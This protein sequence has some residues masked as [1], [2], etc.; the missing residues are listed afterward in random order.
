[1]PIATTEQYLEMI[2]NAKARKFAYP[3]I[4]IVNIEGLTGA[5]EAFAELE[6]DGMVQVSTGGGAHATG[7]T[8]SAWPPATC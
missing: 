3:A 8:P 5:I 1:M 7:S 6:T 2:A 4:N